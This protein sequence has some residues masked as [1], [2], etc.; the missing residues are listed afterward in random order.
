MIKIEKGKCPYCGS[1]NV[2][3]GSLEICDEGVY[4]K[5]FCNDCE[6]NFEEHYDLKFAG[7]VID[8]EFKAI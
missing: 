3:Y 5:V 8:G 7:H 6:N 2:E 1:E 4:Y